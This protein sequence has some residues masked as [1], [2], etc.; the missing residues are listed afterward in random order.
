[1]KVT[2]QELRSREEL[3]AKYGREDVDAWLLRVDDIL[4]EQ[5]ERYSWQ[6]DGHL[7]HIGTSCALSGSDGGERSVLKIQA[8]WCRSPEALALSTWPE[9]LTIRPL[10]SSSAEADGSEWLHLP[11]VGLPELSLADV[12]TRRRVVEEVLHSAVVQTPAPDGLQDAWPIFYA[13][14]VH[15]H[16]WKN[17]TFEM[18]EAETVFLAACVMQRSAARPLLTHGDLLTKNILWDGTRWLAV[19]PIPGAGELAYELAKVTLEF[20]DLAYTEHL[21]NSLR[22]E[23]STLTKGRLEAWRAF[24]A[25]GELSWD[26][27]GDSTSFCED[28]DLRSV[29]HDGYHLLESY[30]LKASDGEM[31]LWQ[32]LRAVMER[33]RILLRTSED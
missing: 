18:P 26:E 11:Y 7:R 28:S 1:M 2:G 24:I 5:K 33:R 4:A 6:P 17:P 23:D 25:Y 3:Y 22:A 21:F 20:A 9:D 29:F 16:G 30:A 15:W 32:E 19:D 27:D 14:A 31:R 13:R 10:R 8:P 12:A